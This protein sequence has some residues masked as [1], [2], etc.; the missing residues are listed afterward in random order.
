MIHEFCDKCECWFS[1]PAG[2]NYTHRCGSD[3][4]AVVFPFSLS[5]QDLFLDDSDY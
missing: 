3:G 5:G 1:H 2:E 4:E